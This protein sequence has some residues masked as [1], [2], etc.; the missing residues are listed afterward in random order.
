VRVSGFRRSVCGWTGRVRSV[1]NLRDRVP[2]TNVDDDEEGRGSS[3]AW[4]STRS[5]VGFVGVWSL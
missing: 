3:D 4:I 1:E 2:E 5:V